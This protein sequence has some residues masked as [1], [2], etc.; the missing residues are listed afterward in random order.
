M[1]TLRYTRQLVT[2]TYIYPAGPDRRTGQTLQEGSRPGETWTP[3][4][5]PDL[6]DDYLVVELRPGG[7]GASPTPVQPPE[8]GWQDLQEEQKELRHPQQE[9]KT[10]P[11]QEERERPQT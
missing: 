10:H 3:V 8:E 6:T 1:T 9:E 4:D 2:V 11:Q 5:P 7:P